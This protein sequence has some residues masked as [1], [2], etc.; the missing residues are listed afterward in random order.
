[1]QEFFR[2][3]GFSMFPVLLCGLAA[4]LVALYATGRPEK[5]LIALGDRLARAELFFAVS[6]LAANV[7]AT[8]HTVANT[9]HTG[10]GFAVMLTTGLYESTAPVVMGLSFLALAHLALAI[11]AFRLAR[12]ES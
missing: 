11:A 9:Q 8:L 1:M 7:A 5:S 10:D 4:L 12:R 2:I 6:G 3:G